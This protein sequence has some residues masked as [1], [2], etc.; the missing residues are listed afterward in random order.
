M[1]TLE[2]IGGKWKPGI[3]WALENGGIMRFGELKRALP[4]ITQKML[5]LQLRELE[6]DH[7]ISRKIFAEVPLRV[8]YQ[9]APYGAP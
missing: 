2:V 3:L 1:T 4:G 8:E 9:L 5:T 6:V 7:I